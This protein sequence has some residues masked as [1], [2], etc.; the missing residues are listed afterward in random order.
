[1][2]FGARSYVNCLLTSSIAFPRQL[3]L[4]ASLVGFGLT[5]QIEN[6]VFISFGT[7]AEGGEDKIFK[8]LLSCEIF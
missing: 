8:L 5:C 7:E 3:T 1:M 6:K 4:I 2:I